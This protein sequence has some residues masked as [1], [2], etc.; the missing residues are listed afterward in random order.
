MRLKTYKKTVVFCSALLAGALCFGCSGSSAADT[1]SLNGNEILYNGAPISTDTKNA[2]YTSTFVEFHDDVAEQYKDTANTIIHITQGGIYQISGEAIDTQIRVNAPK[3]EVTL[4]LNNVNLSCNTAPAILVE[5]AADSET[6]GEAGVTIALNDTSTNM[7]TASHVA[8][9]T[10]EDGVEIDYDG[11]ISSKVSLKIEGN[12][13]LQVTGDKEG[14]ESQ[15]HLTINGGNLTVIAADD[16][17]NASEDGVS[18][19][20]INDGV[21]NCSVQNGE[22]GDGIDSNGYIYINGGSVLA[23]SHSA[24]GDSGLDADLGV[25][26]NGGT[27]CATGNMYEAISEESAQLHAQ[28]YFAEKQK[29]GVPLIVTDT[30]G[31]AILAYTPVNDFTILEFSLPDMIA[32]AT[33]HLYSGGTITGTATNGIY[34]EVQQYENGTQMGHRGI[35]Q[36]NHRPEF[37]ETQ[38]ENF[39]PPADG[40]LPQRPQNES[41]EKPAKPEGFPPKEFNPEQFDPEQLPE[42]FDP[43][44]MSWPPQEGAGGT[45]GR[46]EQNVPLSADFII[47][48]ENNVYTGISAIE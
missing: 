38:P 23:Q 16:P 22:E 14:I 20:T 21:I 34:T 29:G 43:E 7:I 44:N 10:N 30:D 4:V 35:M 41:G 6:A 26:I 13:T 48:S 27:V 8:K 19:I 12:G 32:G 24:S 25:I 17:I 39:A 45:G 9:Y 47:D 28:F 11:A 33:Y 15:M 37:D 1:I 18:V 42:G 31:N 5:N 3:E 46:F 36:N 2:V 40:T